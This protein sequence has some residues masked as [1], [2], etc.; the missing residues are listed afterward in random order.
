MALEVVKI[1]DVQD[2]QARLI[3]DENLELVSQ[4]AGEPPA[5]FRCFCIVRLCAAYC[6]GKA[7]MVR[8]R[9]GIQTRAGGVRCGQIP[10]D[11][12]LAKHRNILWRS[13]SAPDQS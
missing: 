5:A 9:L 2:S 4:C 10:S 7:V 12:G 1:L 11:E 6:G 13:S 3:Y 8:F